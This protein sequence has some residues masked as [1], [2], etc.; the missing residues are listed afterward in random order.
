[1]KPFTKK[2]NVI[3]LF[4]SALFLI[5][6]MIPVLFS[7][8]AM[9]ILQ[10][11]L[12][13]KVFHRSFDINEWGNTVNALIA[14]PIFF[15]IFVDS[16]IFLK[17]SDKSKIIL[18]CFY[19]VLFLVCTGIVTSL[20]SYKDANSDLISELLLGIECYLSK[21]FW[22]TSWNYST[23]IRTINTQLI[24]APLFLFTSDL[25]LIK[26][27]SVVLLIPLLPLCLYY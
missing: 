26:T 6:T 11:F 13:T 9:Y 16:V 4:L 27:I 19:A 23:E 15:V 21:S 25:H 24:T 14:F 20:T 18:L 1:M 12:E 5:M 22:P 8:T 17:F 7:N 10:D 3:F 2:Q